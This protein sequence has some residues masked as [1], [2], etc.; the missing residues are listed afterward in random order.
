MTYT[1]SQ[2]VC[3]DGVCEHDDETYVFTHVS[4]QDSI[5]STMDKYDISEIQAQFLEKAAD[6]E[7]MTTWLRQMIR[8][9][10]CI[11]AFSL[12]P[13]TFSRNTMEGGDCGHTAESDFASK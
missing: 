11:L 2:S 9:C 13:H 3:S 5:F 7:Q 8:T 6:S 12:S 4:E 10:K 1:T